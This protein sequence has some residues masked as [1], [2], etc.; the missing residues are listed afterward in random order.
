MFTRLEVRFV[1]HAQRRPH[2]APR[3]LRRSTLPALLLTLGGGAFAGLATQSATVTSGQEGQPASAQASS[4]GTARLDIGDPQRASRSRQLQIAPAA[5]PPPP[6]RVAAIPPVRVAAIPP[7]RVAAIPPVPVA[8]A[9]AG[10]PK[11]VAVPPKPA[12]PPA[13]ITGACPVPAARFTDTFGD[14]RSGGR[15]HQGTDLMAPAGSPAYAVAAGV[16]RTT[17]S[18][19]GG[20]SLYLTATDGTVFFYAHNSANVARNGQRVEAGQLIAKVGSTG[21]ASGSSPHVHFEQKPGGGRAIN[22]YPLVRRLCG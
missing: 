4:G 1:Q 7:V 9:P 10:K 12:P 8:V 3:D 5:P 15:Q 18:G 6:V 19:A 2:A 22:S 14:P 21:N 11:P 13:R 16:V 20:I 17:S